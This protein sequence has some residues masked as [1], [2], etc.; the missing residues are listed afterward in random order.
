MRVDVK[1]YL[2]VGLSASREQFF[3]KAQREGL[4]EF[5]DIAGN[6]AIETDPIVHDFLWALKIFRGLPVVE[7]LEGVSYEKAIPVTQKVLSLQASIEKAEEDAR[8]LQLEIARIAPFGNFSLTDIDYIEREGHR[9]FQFFYSK[10]D[11]APEIWDHPE[12]FRV[13]TEDGL[14]YYMAINPKPRE[15]HGMVE[16]KI[17]QPLQTLKEQLATVESQRHRDESEIRSL[18]KYDHFLRG[19]LIHRLNETNVRTVESFTAPLAEGALFAIEGWVSQDHVKKVDEFCSQSQIHCEEIAI[20]EEDRI[21][22]YLDNKGP[23]L[24]GEDL[25]NIYDTPSHTDK[26][27]SGWV[28]CSFALFFGMI[29]GDAGY[30]LIYL[31]FSLFLYY[32]Y[33]EKQGYIKR[34][35]KLALILSVTCI[36]WG[37]LIS[38]FFGLNLG[39]DN[40][41]RKMSLMGWLVDKQVEY[42]VENK[43]QIYQDLVKKFPKMAEAKDPESFVDSISEKGRE[44]ETTYPVYEG[45]ADNTLFELALFVGTIHVILSLA[46]YLKKNWSG[47]GWILFLIGAYL[48]FPYKLKTTSLIYFVFGMNPE[49]AASQGLILIY[50]GVALAI[51]LALIRKKWGGIFEFMTVV[52]VFCDV[53]SYLRLYALALAGLMMAVTFNEIAIMVGPVFG[54]LVILAGH[55]INMALGIAGGIIHGLRLN[56]LE[57]YHYSFEGGGKP[58]K[59]LKLLSE[60]DN[61]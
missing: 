54:F 58:F 24:I 5:I 60:H 22:T 34:M 10:R 20:E 29:I 32:K 61:D 7:Q 1:K 26:D 36:V 28:L 50:T 48:Y 41:L 23:G 39:P 9:K 38:S 59:P 15:Y 46:R 19:A 27:P 47:I 30:G 44:G 11:A 2:F 18:A 42:H 53:L 49:V 3:K 6:K 16:V 4:I 43:D 14:D 35:I 33:R 52:Q 51:I 57:W 55:L 37:V 25:V 12:V 21:P 17:E 40:P 45:F 8:L 56:F 13:G 31:L